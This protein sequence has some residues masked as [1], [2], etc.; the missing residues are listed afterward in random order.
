MDCQILGKNSEEKDFKKLL[1]TS[2]KYKL[3]ELV[4]E[5][6]ISQWE[7]ILLTIEANLD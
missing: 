1:K 7:E 2:S 5:N 6:R 4:N 3:H